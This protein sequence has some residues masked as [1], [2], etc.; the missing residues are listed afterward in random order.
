MKTLKDEKVSVLDICERRRIICDRT[1]LWN[2]NPPSKSNTIDPRR[3]HN[4]AYA[5][6]QRNLRI[7]QQLKT[8]NWV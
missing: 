3:L 1:N 7:I 8:R 6:T 2:S 5:V 4:Q